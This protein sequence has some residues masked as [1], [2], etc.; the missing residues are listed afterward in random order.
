MIKLHCSNFRVSTANFL[1]VQIFRIFKIYKI[2][3]HWF[4]HTVMCPEIANRMANILNGKQEQSDL[5]LHCPHLSLANIWII[6]E[7]KWATSWQNQQC[8]Y[9]A[10]NDSDLPGQVDLSLRWTPIILLVLSRDGSYF[11]LLKVYTEL[12]ENF[13]RFIILLWND[14]FMLLVHSV[15]I[16]Y[17]TENFI[18]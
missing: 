3:T 14:M 1:D 18:S 12:I 8:G 11:M 7:V 17:P 10:S 16:Y 15:S 6:T 2:S 9:A 5:G 4:Y 13:C